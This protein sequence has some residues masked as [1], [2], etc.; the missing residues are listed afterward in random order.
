MSVFFTSDLHLGHVKAAEFRDFGGDVDLHDKTI[1]DNINK[2]VGKRAKLFVLGDIAFNAIGLQ[3]INQINCLNIELV[4]GNHDKFHISKYLEII[5][6]ISGFRKY[7]NC[8]LSHCPIHPNEMYRCDY[9]IH[10]HVHK[11]GNSEE[12]TDSRYKNVN[13]DMHNYEVL[14][15]E[16]IF[17]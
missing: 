17:K 11:T 13:I 15:F 4:L 5:P 10:G 9:N 14:L 1:I 16:E 7:N 2:R 12:I 3:K 8:W 6:K